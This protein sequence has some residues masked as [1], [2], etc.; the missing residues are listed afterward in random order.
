MLTGGEPAAKGGI[1]NI[2]PFGDLEL[3]KG[4]NQTNPLLYLLLTPL[5]ITEIVGFR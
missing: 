5:S 4:N 3:V 2:R 1:G